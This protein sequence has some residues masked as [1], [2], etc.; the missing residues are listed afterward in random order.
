M[1]EGYRG[2]TDMDRHQLLKSHF[3]RETEKPQQLLWPILFFFDKLSSVSWKRQ[4]ATEIIDYGLLW[5]NGEAESGSERVNLLG[6]YSTISV[7]TG[8][9]ESSISYGKSY[10]EQIQKHILKQTETAMCCEYWKTDQHGR[11]TLKNTIFEHEA[12][13]PILL[14]PL[15]RWLHH[16]P[17]L[18]LHSKGIWTKMLFFHLFSVDS[19]SFL[20]LSL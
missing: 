19:C 16:L 2:S 6:W 13:T 17:S 14:G 1:P 4:K 12:D 11:K 20:P 8:H 15:L 10:L 3:M 18:L 9:G 5:E 7:S